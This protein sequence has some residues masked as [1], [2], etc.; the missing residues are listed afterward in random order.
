MF[1]DYRGLVPR[2][3]VVEVIGNDLRR[4]NHEASLLLI[5]MRFGWVTESQHV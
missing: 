4:S 5:E 3:C 1:R 2:D